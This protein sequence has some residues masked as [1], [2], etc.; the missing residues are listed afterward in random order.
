MKQ[1]PPNK[2]NL[3]HA[4]KLANSRKGE[5]L[6]KKYLN[7]I[8]KLLW[9]C[10]EGH[11]WESSYNVV[12]QGS[13]CPVCAKKRSGSSQRLTIEHAKKL[14][15]SKRGSCLS[16][17]YVNARVPL[18]WKCIKGHTWSAAYSSIKSGGWCPSCAQVT[19]NKKLIKYS[20]DDMKEFAKKRSG[21]C[22]SRKYETA[23]NKLKWQCSLGHTWE[24]SFNVVQQGSWCP[25]CSKGFG[26]RLCRVIFEKMFNA[27]FPSS[28]PSWLKNNRGFQ[29]EL[30]GYCKD[31][32]IAFE[33]HGLQHY[34]QMKYFSVSRSFNKQKLHD[35]EKIKICKKNKVTLVEIPE[36][37]SIL[38]VSEVKD[39]ILRKIRQHKLQGKIVT[40]EISDSVIDKAYVG[41]NFQ[42]LSELS[43]IVISKGGLLLS[44]SYRGSNQYYS[45]RC[46]LGHEWDI[47]GL[48]LK[49]GH[50]CPVCYNTTRGSSQRLNIEDAK[51]IAIKNKG[52]C[53]SKAYANAQGKLRWECHQK[54]VWLANYNSIQRGSWCP[55][56]SLLNKS[57]VHRKY[58][59]EDAKV[60]ASKMNGLCLSRSYVSVSHKLEW[61]CEVGH[62]WSGTFKD[63]LKGSWC[64]ECGI[65]KAA[66]SRIRKGEQRI[67]DI[68]TKRSGILLS[69]Y[70][71]VSYQIKLRCKNGHIFSKRGDQLYLGQWCTVCRKNK[72]SD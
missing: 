33:H 34:K 42:M 25:E 1:P 3:N 4:V 72:Q 12:Q 39:Y 9:K 64:P 16:R 68:I 66:Q 50:W 23:R 70:K 32:G 48:N 13:W 53:L 63:V 62:R 69:E 17:T 21:K 61:K 20:I 56:C 55:K 15:R 37:G 22:L 41:G 18:M 14:A 46:K 35:A 71:G 67:L 5:C 26:E 57:E 60:A 45:V 44:N 29:F 6:S 65:K 19:R 51:R 36:V 7:A 2:L 24:V 38:K 43:S 30:D 59:I 28:H 27:K 58:C 47:L 49:K 52:Q 11:T 8:S 40:T 54:H 10:K 31:L